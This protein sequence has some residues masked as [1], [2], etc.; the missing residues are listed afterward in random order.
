MDK[1]EKESIERLEQILTPGKTFTIKET[2]SEFSQEKEELSRLLQS[3]PGKPPSNTGLEKQIE[4]LKGR[5]GKK[6][7]DW[8]ELVDAEEKTS[9]NL[10]RMN[11]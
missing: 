10:G 11:S 1:K 5:I 2:K 6:H 9:K 8:M 4:D 3:L 7:R